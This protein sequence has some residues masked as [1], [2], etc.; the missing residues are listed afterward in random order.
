MCLAVKE[1]IV[2]SFLRSSY[3]QIASRRTIVRF[4]QTELEFWTSVPCL[5]SKVLEVVKIILN[6]DF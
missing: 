1:F 6:L 3:L 5:S 2:N 4:G